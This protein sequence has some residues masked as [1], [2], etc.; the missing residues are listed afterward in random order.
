MSI[1]EYTHQEEMLRAMA[2][3]S[4]SSQPDYWTQR[5]AA[6]KTPWA[7]HGVPQNLAA[8]LC[9]TTCSSRILIPAAGAD[10]EAIRAFHKAGH[11][12]TAIDFCPVA[13]EQ[14]KNALGTLEG[15]ITLGDFFD[16]DLRSKPFDLVYER[17][18]LC[19]LPPRVWEDYA[20]R[21][22]GLLRAGGKLVGFFFYGNESD[23]PP[24]PLSDK[25]ALKLFE[26]QFELVRTE[27]VS[28]SLPMFTGTERW[29]EWRRRDEVS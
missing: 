21:I 6:G 18:F 4:D 19:S 1:V 10:P 14:A 5:Y 12:V 23:P 9:R 17:T 20:S 27:A 15:K 26:R 25:E 22:A 29:Q 16:C 13:V 28:D 11:E 24:Y 2:G 3:I 8:F 7:F